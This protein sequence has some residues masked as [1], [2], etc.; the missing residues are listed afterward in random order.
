MAEKKI[1][2]ISKK[3]K[4]ISI[5]AAKITPVKPKPVPVVKESLT[6]QPKPAPEPPKSEAKPPKK[7]AVKKLGDNS[8]RNPDGTFRKGNQCSV[9][10]EGGR[11]QTDF[12]HRAMAKARAKRDPERIIR[13]LDE[14]DRI[15]DSDK[16]SPM[17]KMKALEI[18]IKLNGNFD[19]QETK[20]VTPAKPV[21]SPLN[22]LSVE[23]LRGLK[24]LKALRQKEAK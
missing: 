21:E 18:K 24:A 12:S 7:K 13:D 9:G 10:N 11:P 22:N 2:N 3:K 8:G 14:L 23:E 1:V 17:E 15:L 16:S 20:D 6:A 5:S 19:P 4:P